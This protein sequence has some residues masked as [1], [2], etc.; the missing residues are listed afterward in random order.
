MR[1]GCAKEATGEST[2]V[3]GAECTP[4]EWFHRHE[5]EPLTK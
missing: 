4:T 2:K 3:D 5:Q 1:Q